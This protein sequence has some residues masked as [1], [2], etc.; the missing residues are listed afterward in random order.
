MGVSYPKAMFQKSREYC[1][2][3]SPF[4]S[5]SVNGGHQSYY[6][7]TESDYWPIEWR[8]VVS[9]FAFIFIL[10]GDSSLASVTLA[11]PLQYLKNGSEL[12]KKP[13]ADESKSHLILGEIFPNPLCPLL[14]FPPFH[15]SNRNGWV[16]VHV[17]YLGKACELFCC[18][19]NVS[20]VI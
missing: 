1:S 16:T 8:E 12:Q 13:T 15:R 9:G 10:P 6:Q 3:E 20:T 2:Y 7:V 11:A 4:G 18:Y 19:C 5:K 14:L 17:L